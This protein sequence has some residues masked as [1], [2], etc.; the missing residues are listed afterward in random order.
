MMDNLAFR[1]NAAKTLR[2]LMLMTLMTSGAGVH[3]QS[4]PANLL[5]LSIEELFSVDIHDSDDSNETNKNRWNF[6]YS[7]QRSY[8][9][10]YSDGGKDLSYDDVLWVPGQETRTDKNF[11]VVPTHI[12][13]NVHALVLGYKFTDKLS[14]RVAVP[15]ITQSTDHISIVPGYSEFNISSHGLGDISVLGSRHFAISENKSW[16][17]GLGLSLPTGS[18]DEQGDT[19]RAPGEQQLPYTMQL[20]SGTYDIPVVVSYLN[21]KDTFSWGADFAAKA[22]LGKNDRH[23][24]L[25]NSASVSGWIKLTTINWIE[26]SLR[27][28]YRY[29]DKISGEDSSLKVPGAFP[30]PAPVVDPRLFGGKQVDLLF[31]LKIPI[32]NPDQYVDL[33]VGRPVYQSLNGPQS[34]EDYR[35]SLSLNLGF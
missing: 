15:Y 5:D 22:R 4:V 16:V 34:S 6:H 9:E 7:Y 31:G 19:P 10:N 27:L 11:P 8:F 21:K 12:E 3:A 18:I 24:R 2:S 20:G 28:T 35:L 17:L 33:V 32:S 29:T 25:G 14:V 13:Q 30:Y 1:G 26:P 23:Y